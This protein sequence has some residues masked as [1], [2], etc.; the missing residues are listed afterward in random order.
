MKE[1]LA[2][3]TAEQATINTPEANSGTAFFMGSISQ[4]V[5]IVNINFCRTTQKG[6]HIS[7]PSDVQAPNLT[8]ENELSMNAI[9]GGSKVNC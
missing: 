6:Q 7:P 1:S 4:S 5:K 8:S 9:P 2:T 3:P